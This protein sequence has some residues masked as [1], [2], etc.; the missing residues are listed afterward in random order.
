MLLNLRIFKKLV[1]SMTVIKCKKKAF[2]FCK[3]FDVS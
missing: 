3:F 1:M 2:K